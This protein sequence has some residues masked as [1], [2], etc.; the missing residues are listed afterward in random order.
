MGFISNCLYRARWCCVK[1]GG[2]R[3]FRL[4]YLQE[5]KRNGYIWSGVEHE[6]G[7]LGRL[8]SPKWRTQ[9]IEGPCVVKP[10]H[11][12]SPKV[13][14]LWPREG[15]LEEAQP[16][17]GTLSQASGGLGEKALYR[18]TGSRFWTAWIY[19]DNRTHLFS[20]IRFLKLIYMGL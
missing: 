10:K 3:R 17:P 15:R 2:C 13:T 8:P 1:V 6:H 11:L 5:S 18:R 20:C 14:L 7:K 9:H 12:C 16:G 19:L 4:N